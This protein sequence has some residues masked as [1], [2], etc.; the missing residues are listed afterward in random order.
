M[1]KFDR[2]VVRLANCK[3]EVALYEYLQAIINSLFINVNVKKYANTPPPENDKYII[4]KYM[5]F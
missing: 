4:Y 3:N 1:L 5:I 2:V